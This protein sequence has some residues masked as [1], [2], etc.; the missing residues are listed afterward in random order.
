LKYLAI[1]VDNRG[2]KSTTKVVV[3]AQRIN[4]NQHTSMFKIYSAV[5]LPELVTGKMMS[6]PFLSNIKSIAKDRSISS[7]SNGKREEVV[8][9]SPN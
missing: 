7:L 5:C 3:K 6:R 4:G 9:E 8:K 2:T 1:D